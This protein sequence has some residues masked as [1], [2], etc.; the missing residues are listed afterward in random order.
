[1]KSLLIFFHT[2]VNTGYAIGPLES[3][4]AEVGYRLMGGH[5]RVHFS[6]TSLSH[7]GPPEVPDGITNLLEFDPAD[8]G[9][10]N[11]RRMMQYVRKHGIDVAMGF[12]QSPQAPCLGSMRKAGVR[13][14][15]SYLGGP[16]SSLNRG[17]KLLAKKLEVRLRSSAPDHYIFESQAMAQ[18]G[19][20]G[21]GIRAEDTSVVY[22]GVDTERYR[23]D[24]DTDGLV[25]E[26]FGIPRDRKILLFTG[27]MEERKG[28]RALVRAAVELRDNRGRQ[29]FHWLILGNQRGEERP[30][31]DLL[32][33]A[34]ASDHVTFGG[35]SYEVPNILPDCYLGTIAS[36]GWDSFTMSAVEMASA[37]LPLLVSDLQGLSETID[38][39]ATGYTFPPGDHQRLADLV[40]RLLDDPRARND[41]SKRARARILREFT[42]ESQIAGITEVCRTVFSYGS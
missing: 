24:T 25:Y 37:G 33:G 35:Y 22:L 8:P 7:G 32:R 19:I 3:V 36:T 17:L 39:G 41:L 10:A 11:R 6:Y 1:M 16:L 9:R 15:V 2:P 13:R 14:I 5:E 38:V 34:K 27:H 21:R 18:S 23:P 42:V 29:D 30:F 4:F 12:D 20:Q 40:E 31:L 28:I 26:R